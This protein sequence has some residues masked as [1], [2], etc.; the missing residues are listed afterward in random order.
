M[1]NT[2]EQV[3]HVNVSAVTVVEAD[4]KRGNAPLD[5]APT[6]TFVGG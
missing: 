4:I 1:E 5:A 6:Y 3:G 2:Y